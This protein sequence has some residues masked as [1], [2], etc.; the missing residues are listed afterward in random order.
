MYDLSAPSLLGVSVDD[1]HY[2]MAAMKRAGVSSFRMK[3][4]HLLF[5][6]CLE[7]DWGNVDAVC[8]TLEQVLL[9]RTIGALILDHPA[10]FAQDSSTVSRKEGEREVAA[11]MLTDELTVAQAMFVIGAAW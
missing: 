6:N 11:D 5:S 2:Q 3:Y 10:V 7:T 4:F 8:E 1:I 9:W